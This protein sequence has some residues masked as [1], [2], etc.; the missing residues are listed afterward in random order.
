MP[1]FQAGARTALTLCAL[2]A[3]LSSAPSVAQSTDQ[4]GD[5]VLAR[6]DGQ[7]IRMSDVAA[8]VESLPD[9]ARSLPPTTLFPMMLDQLIDARALVAEARKTGADQDP[10]VRRQ[11][12]QAAQRALESAL[13]R[14]EVQPMIS[15]AAV[16]ARYERDIA[17]KPG[18]EEVRAR[19]ILVDTEALAK[20]IIAELKQGGDFVALSGKHSKD[21]GAS[22]GGGDLG[23]FK[24]GDMVPEFSAA[25]YA[26]KN[27][28]VSATPVK[29]QFGWHVI[30]TTERRRSAPESFEDAKE[31]LRQE[32]IK[33]A[34]QKVL[35]R[36]R[37]A[38]TVERMNMDGSV[39]RI[40]DSAEPPRGR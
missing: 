1:R 7:P 10:E 22:R 18:T 27:G 15:D 2:L 16:R 26:L 36:A 8:M 28:E 32:I 31:E 23:F 11:V 9:Q 40:T 14:R 12:A 4:S 35:A 39:P 5:R 21:P 38:V 13:L 17:N 34:V 6:I 33:E 19:H 20:T 29:T 25:A 24:R 30:Q 37:A 3:G